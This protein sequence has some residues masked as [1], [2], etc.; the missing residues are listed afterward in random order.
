MI[1][2]HMECMSSALVALLLMHSIAYAVRLDVPV[3]Q[4]FQYTL[5][6]GQHVCYFV[7]FNRF[8]FP[9]KLHPIL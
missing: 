5:D 4:Y 8:K 3:G 7:H 9:K 2:H 1:T 6:R